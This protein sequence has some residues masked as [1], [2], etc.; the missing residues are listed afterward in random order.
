M[1]ALP[2]LEVG[3]LDLDIVLNHVSNGNICSVFTVTIRF[4][5]GYL[6]HWRESYFRFFFEETC[7]N[8]RKERLRALVS[9]FLGARG[10]PSVKRVQ[11][12]LLE[13]SM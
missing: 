8:T 1:P 12:Q 10:H 3:A 7:D 9:M 6:C 5:A 2:V 4:S 13:S 11:E